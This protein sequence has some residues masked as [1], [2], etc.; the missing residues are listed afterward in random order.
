MRRPFFSCTLGIFFIAGNANDGNIV[1]ARTCVPSLHRV[2]F[3]LGNEMG[4][5]DDLPL[6][7]EL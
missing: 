7:V 1:D 4:H 3:A 5:S 2:L 6:Q